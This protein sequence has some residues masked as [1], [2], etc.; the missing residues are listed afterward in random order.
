MLARFLH[1]TKV[2]YSYENHRSKTYQETTC[3]VGIHRALRL[4]AVYAETKPYNIGWKRRVSLTHSG[5]R[6]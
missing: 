4:Q 1:N 3:G 5:M 6:D 2:R